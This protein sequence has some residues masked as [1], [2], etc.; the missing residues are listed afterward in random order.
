MLNINSAFTTHT[1]IGMVTEN[2]SNKEKLT[3]KTII[4]LN[5][6]SFSILHLL[7]NT[8]RDSRVLL[9]FVYFIWY[10]CVKFTIAPVYKISV[11]GYGYDKDNKRIVFFEPTTIKIRVS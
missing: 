7:T 6:A 1:H 4:F 9:S 8:F 11:K 3:V 2:V 10:Q 5:M